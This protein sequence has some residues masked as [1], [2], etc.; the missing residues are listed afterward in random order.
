LKPFTLSEYER[1]VDNSVVLEQDGRGV[2]VLETPDGPIVKIFRQKRL[3]S[4]ALLKP[5]AIRFLENARALKRIGV[6]AVEVEDVFYC[7]P[8]KKA[9]VFYQPIPG[10]SLRAVLQSRVNFDDM[11]ESFIVFLADLHDKGVL[12]RS[13]HLNNIIVENCSGDLGLIDIAD[14]KIGEKSLSRN[15]RMRNFRHLTRYKAD[16][17]SIKSYGIERFMDIYF[18][19]S[20][21]PLLYKQEF[22]VRMQE[23][24]AAEGRV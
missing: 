13:I 23:A 22:L 12:F 8:L 19:A 1:L 2:K 21:L 20:H 24:V 3:F 9:L 18:K 7:K 5:Y 6:K 17:E 14:M 10:Q 15:Q 11:M 16:Q 4:S